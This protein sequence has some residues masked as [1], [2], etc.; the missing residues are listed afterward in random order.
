MTRFRSH[1]RPLHLRHAA[2][3]L[4]AARLLLLLLAAPAE[5]ET[6]HLGRGHLAAVGHGRLRGGGGGGAGGTLADGLVEGFCGWEEEG[7]ERRR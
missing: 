3:D 2:V 5:D 1:L 4:V 7:E 6:L